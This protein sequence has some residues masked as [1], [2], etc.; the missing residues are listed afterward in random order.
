MQ[1]Q[2]DWDEWGGRRDEGQT[3]ESDGRSTVTLRQRQAIVSPKLRERTH[4][5]FIFLLTV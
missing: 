2:E 4:S 5:F 1:H 3:D